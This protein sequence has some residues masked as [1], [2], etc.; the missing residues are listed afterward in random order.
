MSLPASGAAGGP[1]PI[2][3]EKRDASVVQQFNE[4]ACIVACAEMLL[5]SRGI[6]TI[7]QREIFEVARDPNVNSF[8]AAALNSFSEIRWK[9]GV[10]AMGDSL[11]VLEPQIRALSTKPWSAMFWYPG[12]G[13][14]HNVVVDSV[15]QKGSVLI[16]D[17]RQGTRYKMRMQEFV[18]FWGLLGVR[19][20]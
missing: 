3:D 14:G 16:R 6:Q 13:M 9:N 7:D 8:V 20:H 2:F 18:N 1:W 12:V 19:E 15:D 4:L 11:E 5:K 17:P 10:L